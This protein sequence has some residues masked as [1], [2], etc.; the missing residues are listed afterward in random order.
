MF[1][2]LLLIALAV[3]FYAMRQDLQVRR[4]E[5]VAEKIN[6][7]VRLLLLSDLH[8]GFYGKDQKTLVAHIRAC[9]PDAILLAGDIADDR[10]PFVGTARLL[11]AVAGDYP[12]YYVAG[13]HEFRTG[14]IDT[15]KQKI[16]TFGVTVLAGQTANLKLRGQ[17]LQIA[18]IDDPAC[19]TYVQGANWQAELDTCA[20]QR[21]R[22]AY[23]VLLTHRP[24][25][26]AAYQKS[27]FDLVLAGHA[28]GGQVRIPGL[29]NG[30]YAPNQGLFPR[31]AGGRYQLGKTTLIVS[32]GLC[33]NGLP[34]VFNRPELVF[35]E[36][37]PKKA[38]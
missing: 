22:A 24:E 32:R 19:E 4:Y 15:V 25:R 14:E 35:V 20:A 27:G 11:S 17:N 26:V 34:R 13:N 38:K 10:A 5:L 21:D 33:R 8:S 12:C 1:W 7:P 37:L 23:S 30:I 9:R 18:G 16:A 31:Y 28:H 36:L 3:L 29:L 2:I 6:A